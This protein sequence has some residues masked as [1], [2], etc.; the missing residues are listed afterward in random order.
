MID[1]QGMFLR[2]AKRSSLIV[3]IPKTIFVARKFCLANILHL[4][5]MGI[6]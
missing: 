5:S 1:E 3:G 2:K 4:I 6:Y